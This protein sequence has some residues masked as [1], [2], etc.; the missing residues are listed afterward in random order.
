MRASSATDIGG[1]AAAALLA[2]FGALVIWDTTS[3]SDFDSAMFPRT[4]AMIMIALCIGY[5]AMWLAGL[6]RPLPQA[7]S[8]SWPRRIGLVLT[9]LAAGFAM[10]W[11]GFIA[12]SLALFAVLTVLAMYER[13]TPARMIVYPLVGI[14]IVVGF[15][16]L[17]GQFL[18]VPLPVGQIFGWRLL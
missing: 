15:Y 10:P 18:R 8:G 13:W 5:I 9:M 4:V 14:A 11:S 3:Y 1:V 16:V 12:S 7:E 17:F 6:A 2:L